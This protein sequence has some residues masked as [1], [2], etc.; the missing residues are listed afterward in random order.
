MTH[1]QLGT[2]G[3]AALV[4]ALVVSGCSGGGAPAGGGGDENAETTL[5]FFTTEPTSLLPQ[6]NAGSQASMAMCANLMEMNVDSQEFEP[7]VAESVESEDAQNWTIKLRE[8]WTFHD[9]SPLN[10]SAYVDAWNYTATGANAWQG[11]GNFASFEGYN[12]LNP[13]DGSIPTVEGLSG[14]EAVDG[15]TIEVAL[16]APNS[17]FPKLLA[18]NPLC[19]LPPQALEDPDAF[20]EAFVG[21]GP[22]KFVQWDHNQQIVMEKWDEFKGDEGFTGGAD[23]LVAKVYTAVDA[24]YTDMTAGN[25]DMIRNVPAA[26]VTRAKSQLGGESLY[27]VKTQSK[28]YTLQ[29]PEYIS[30]L[31]DPTLRKAI[32]MSIDREAIATSLL[33]GNADPSDSLVPPSL[34]SYRE[35]ACEA[36]TFDPDEAKALLE[37]AGGFDGTFNIDYSGDSDAQLVQ[38]IAKQIQ[39]NLGIKVQLNPMLNT[40]L[41]EK[42][43]NQGLSGAIFGLWG[44][45]YKSPDQYLSQ[46][47]TNGDGNSA[48]GYSNPEVD[49]VL[50]AARGS[51]DE[52]ER[53]DLYAEAEALILEDQPAIPLFIPKDY[54]LRTEC[55]G[56]NDVLGDLQF[57]R[58]DYVC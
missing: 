40:E 53:A 14:V 56:M 58:A 45:A 17:D 38:A 33:E 12:E 8:G 1:R 26:M 54:G 24:A 50:V 10:A 19:P 21:S 5:S 32:S 11:N 23:K 15:L 41:Q 47:E 2:T 46:Y 7:L 4:A 48:T 16:T 3:A 37:E 57:Y 18:T 49:K 28:Q 9:G 6:K 34:N 29:F 20:E 30:E 55:A 35:G 44:W 36:C 39:D 52:Q 31:K 13:T 22:Y 43:N 51:Q 25:L 42:R 27:E